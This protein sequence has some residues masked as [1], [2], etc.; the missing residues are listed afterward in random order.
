MIKDSWCGW[1]GEWGAEIRRTGACGLLQMPRVELVPVLHVWS[2]ASVKSRGSISQV[3]ESLQR[4]VGDVKITMRFISLTVKDV[5]LHYAA[6]Y[7][8]LPQIC[9]RVSILVATMEPCCLFSQET[10]I[11]HHLQEHILKISFLL[12]PPTL[13]FHLSLCV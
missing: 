11:D 9:Y 13:D 5:I 7:A 6:H 1:G 2:L 3:L 12:S 4:C 8:L 10:D